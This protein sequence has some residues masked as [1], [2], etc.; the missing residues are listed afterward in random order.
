MQQQFQEEEKPR[1]SVP[2]AELTKEQ[3]AVVVTPEVVASIRKRLSDK[4]PQVQQAAVEAL[5][6]MGQEGVE[7]LLSVMR[8]ENVC[9]KKRGNRIIAAYVSFIVLLGVISAFS[10]GNGFGVIGSFSGVLGAAF[11]ASQTQKTGAV[12]LAKSEDLRAIPFLIE[13]LNF[14]ELRVFWEARDGLIQLLPRMRLEHAN[15]LSQENRKSLYAFLKRKPS[16]REKN[17]SKESELRFAIL[18]ALEQVGDETSIEAVQEVIDNPL[19]YN[20]P[21]LQEAAA[22]CL[23]YIRA[24]L[25]EVQNAQTL[26]RASHYTEHQDELLRPACNTDDTPANELL[27]PESK[28][29]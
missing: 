23:A 29:E 27:R 12:A 19:R 16:R 22:D 6:E 13:A 10:H 9:R 8:E 17:P 25:D 5:L 4:K 2:L 15:L 14:N 21:Q 1:A 7:L 24:H 28:P 11:A 18:K 3:G 26:L 20:S